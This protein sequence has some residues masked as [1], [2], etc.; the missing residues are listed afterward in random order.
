MNC[1]MNRGF[2]LKANGELVCS[3][4]IGE[5]RILTRIPCPIPHGFDFVR[6]I[7][8][9]KSFAHI[10]E[11]LIRNELPFAN[12]R[13]CAFLDRSN[14]INTPIKIH[15]LSRV[16]IESSYLCNLSC[17]CCIRQSERTQLKSPPYNLSTATLSHILESLNRS[18][19]T[20]EAF[21]FSGRGEPLMN[22]HFWDLALAIKEYSPG[23]QTTLVSNGNFPFCQRFV[24]PRGVDQYIFSIDG[25][26]QESYQQYRR[27]G[28]IAKAHE[29]VRQ[30]CSKRMPTQRVVYKYVLFEFNDSDEE[31][32]AARA[33]CEDVGVDELWLYVTDTPYASKRFGLHSTLAPSTGTCHTRLFFRPEFHA[34]GLNLQAELRLLLDTARRAE[35]LGNTAAVIQCVE[36]YNKLEKEFPYVW[37]YGLGSEGVLNVQQSFQALRDRLIL[38]IRG[39]DRHTSVPPA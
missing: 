37:R 19:F 32:H 20:L 33:F 29:L 15:T 12:C 10:R 35:A 13:W 9:C 34:I 16:Y 17:L 4:G 6:D 22:P 30:V 1:A 18:G 3:C 2:Y 27:G 39:Y 23:S 25:F 36:G 11:A 14:D 26:F 28:E 5:D 7:Y 21:H 8:N 38:R 31:I 24:D